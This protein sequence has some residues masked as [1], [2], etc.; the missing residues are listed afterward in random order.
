MIFQLHNAFAYRIESTFSASLYNA[1]WPKF[2]DLLADIEDMR[3][4]HSLKNP[5]VLSSFQPARKS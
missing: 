5:P 3:A 2:A 4:I 1:I